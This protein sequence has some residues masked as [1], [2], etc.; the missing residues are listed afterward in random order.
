MDSI[1][2]LD[3]T[4]AHSAQCV[5]SSDLHF[6]GMFRGMVVMG[7]KDMA[8]VVVV[9]MVVVVAMVAALVVDDPGLHLNPLP[10]LLMQL[11]FLHYFCLDGLTLYPHCTTT[12]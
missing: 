10:C 8:M 3:G 5:T 6:R 12:L 9:V 11:K 4:K 7:I 1:M 2:T